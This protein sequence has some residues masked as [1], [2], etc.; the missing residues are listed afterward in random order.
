MLIEKIHIETYK[1]GGIFHE[2]GMVVIIVV[3]N[4]IT[5]LQWQ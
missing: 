1:N 3:Y 4:Y 2:E 5:I